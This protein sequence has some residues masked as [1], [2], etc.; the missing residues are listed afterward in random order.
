MEEIAIPIT[1]EF[2]EICEKIV[3]ENLSET[4]WSAIENDDMFQSTSFEGGFDATEN[5]FTFSY[6]TNN[7]EYWFQLRLEEVKKIYA[8]QELTVKGTLADTFI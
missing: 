4:E 2:K 8:G 7:K 3:S 5:A 1:S 6:F